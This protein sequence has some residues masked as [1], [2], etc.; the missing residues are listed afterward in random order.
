M[1]ITIALA[2]AALATTVALPAAAETYKLAIT[3]VEGLE[4]AP[5]RLGSVQGRAGTRDRARA[6]EFFPVE[7]AAQPLPRRCAPSGW[8]S[9]SPAR[10]NTSSSASWL[11]PR[12]RSIGLSRPDYFCALGGDGRFRGS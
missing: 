5:D 12:N 10:R 9:S 11:M 4:Q 6:F 8:T 1:R 3:D 7:R 2:A